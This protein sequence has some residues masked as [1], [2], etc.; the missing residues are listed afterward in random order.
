MAGSSEAETYLRLA[1]E[2][3]LLA[4]D[5]GRGIRD[6]FEGA[7]IRRVLSAAGALPAEVGLHVLQEYR[8]AMAFRGGHLDHMFMHGQS[9]E[10]TPRQR[11]S[12]Q[13]IVVGQHDFERGKDRWTL[14]RLLFADDGCHLKLSGTDLD[15]ARGGRRHH[16]VMGRL[17]PQ[18][19]NQPNPQAITLSDDRGTTVIAHLGSSGW[20]GGTWQASYAS[21][22]TLSADTRW[23]ELDGTR[24]DLPERRPTPV[25]ALEPIEQLE[26]LR[27]ALYA[28]ILST[29]RRHGGA[30]TVEIAFQALVATGVCD[31]DD[32]M[33]AELR[34]IADAV[35]TLS[36][37][38]GLPEPWASLVERFETNDGPTGIV[39]IGAAVDDLDGF[40]IRVDV[41]ISEPTSFSLAIA[42]SPGTPLMRHF[43][44]GID[45]E[46]SPITWWAEDDRGNVYVAFADRGGGSNVVAEGQVTS[47][48]SLDPKATE[49]R[50]F[51]TGSGV[52]GVLR[53][54]LAGLTEHRS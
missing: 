28:E 38:P 45:I 47:L 4:E 41:L 35:N 44:G 54:P 50:I 53:V 13:R 42:I 23:I 5:S 18:R 51:P 30:D 1:C 24:L 39:P 19:S 22:H 17:G 3:T 12:A 11:L 36:S 46:A 32:A 34:R 37:T 21:G 25:I 6:A 33:L 8:L 9:T 20:G 29:D 16:M 27:A 43:P 14:E 15:G 48:A 7:V 49:L 26:P 10:Q 31:D 2:R 52:R 40:S